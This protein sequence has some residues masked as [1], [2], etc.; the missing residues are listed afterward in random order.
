MSN[1]LPVAEKEWVATIFMN[2]LKER[3][4]TMNLTQE[5]IAKA[6]NVNIKTYRSWEKGT[7]PNAIDLF[8]L[9]N[10]LGCDVDFLLG[11][12]CEESHFKSYINK[13]FSLSPEAFEKL[14]LLRQ[15]QNIKNICEDREIANDISYI[16]E[17]LINTENGNYLLDQIRLYTT[18]KSAYHDTNY[19]YKALMHG[20]ERFSTPIPSG[21]EFLI[22]IKDSLDGMSNWLAQFKRAKFITLKE[23]E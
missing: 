14:S 9:A 13:Y 4:K 6:L 2:N 15:Y 23:N 16:L 11:R 18:N 22:A 10:L 5:Y 8:N 12:M 3:R 20:K 17:Y 19:H 1:I 21:I 7:L